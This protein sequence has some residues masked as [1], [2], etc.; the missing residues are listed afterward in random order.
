MS[1]QGL[2]LSMILTSSEHAFSVKCQRLN[3]LGLEGHIVYVHYSA[4]QWL[5][6]SSL[7]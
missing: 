3:M 4:L 2:Y 5:P 1:N 7:G 6:K